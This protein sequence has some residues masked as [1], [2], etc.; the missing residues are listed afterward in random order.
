VKEKRRKRDTKR[1]RERGREGGREGRE[2]EKE[3]GGGGKRP[4]YK[5]ITSLLQ[6]RKKYMICQFTH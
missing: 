2:R 4:T 1:Q 5:K 6:G 3:R